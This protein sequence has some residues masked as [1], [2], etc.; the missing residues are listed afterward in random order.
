MTFIITRY[1]PTTNLGFTPSLNQTKQAYYYPVLREYVL[2]PDYSIDLLNVNIDTTALLPGETL[3]TRI[4]YAYQGVNDPIVLQIIDS[5]LDALD[6][7]RSAHTFRNS[8]IN[9]Y[10]VGYESFNN[11]MYIQ[12]PSLNTSLVNL[13]NTQYQIFFNDALIEYGITQAQYNAIVSSNAQLLSIVNTMYEYIQQNLA[14][15]FGIDFNTFAPIYFTQATNYLNIQNAVNAGNV[16]S[17]YDFKVIKKGNTPITNNI[18][19]VN[20]QDPPYYWPNM[21]NI[22]YDP[23]LGTKGYETNLGA[24]ILGSPSNTSNYPYI[25][26]LNQFDFSNC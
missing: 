10:V 2:D 13:L 6:K 18:I 22:P 20:R 1:W 7:Y 17:N 16:S 14:I 8:L 11:R 21:K 4:V 5:S 24:P 25:I 19:E 23:V 15:Y 3:Y 26:S 9:K 12:S